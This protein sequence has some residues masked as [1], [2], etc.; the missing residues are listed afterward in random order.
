[1]MR[2]F[3]SV[4]VC[5]SCTSVF[6]GIVQH[7]PQHIAG[8]RG[9]WNATWHPSIELWPQAGAGASF[10]EFDPAAIESEVDNVLTTHGGWDARVIVSQVEWV[11]DPVPADLDP[12]A[13]SVDIDPGTLSWFSAYAYNAGAGSW[14]YGS[15]NYGSFAAA[16]LA[17][18]ATGDSAVFEPNPSQWQAIWKSSAENPHAGRDYWNVVIDVPESLIMHYLRNPSADGLFVGSRK[19][20][21]DIDVFGYDQWG[22]SVD[23]RVEIAPPPQTAPWITP[24]PA[25]L[26]LMMH[27]GD[28]IS[29]PYSVAVNNAGSGMLS[30]TAAEAPEVPWITL[31]NPSGSNG[32]TFDVTIDVTDMTPGEY[33]GRIDITDAAAANAPASVWIDLTVFASGSPQIELAPSELNMDLAPSAAPPAAMPVVVDNPAFGVLNWT[34]S[35]V[36][37][38]VGWLSLSNTTGSDGDTLLVH[39]DHTGVARGTHTAQI[40]VSDPAAE[41]SPQFIPV[42]LVVRDQDADLDLACGYDD[43]WEDGATGWVAH[44]RELYGSKDPAVQTHGFVVRLGDSITYANPGGQWA[45]YGSGKTA[46]DAAICNWMHSGDTWPDPIHNNSP[47]GWY[48]SR[49]DVPGRNG[50]YTA[51]SSI[52]TEGMLSGWGGLPSADQMFTA[53]D[54]NPDGKQYRDAEIVVILLGTNDV[55]GPRP[56]ASFIADL[57]AIV[58]RVEVNN[59]VVA[60]TT[61]PPR[62]NRESAVADYNAA[63]RSLA[64]SRHLPLIDLYEEIVRR[65]PD[66]SWDGTLISSDGVHPSASHGGYSA[67]SSPYTDNGAAL[68]HSGYLLWCWLTVQKVNEIKGKCFDEEPPAE[69]LDP[70]DPEVDVV[71]NTEDTGLAFYAGPRNQAEW[72]INRG[73]SSTVRIKNHDDPA[74]LKWDLSVYAGQTVTHAELHVARSNPSSEVFALAAATINTDWDEGTTGNGVDGNPCWRYR[75]YNAASPEESVEWTFPGSDFTT[76]S[77]GNFGSLTTLSSK[78][79]GT[80]KTYDDGGQTWI[81]MKLDPALVH[82]MV[83]DQYGLT[84]TDGRGRTWVNPSIY[85]SEQSSALQPRLYLKTTQDDVTGPGDVAG[86]TASPGEWDGEVVLSFAAPEDTEDGRAFGYDVRYSIGSDFAAA[87]PV[88]RWRIPRPLDAGTVQTVFIEHLDPQ[89]EYHFFVQAYDKAGNRGN[90]VSTVLTL[91]AASDVPSLIDGGFPVPDPTGKPILGVSGVLSLWACS[92]LAKVNPATGNR[93][94]DGYAGAGND[95]YKKANAVWDS[96]TATVDLPAGRNEVVAFQLIIERL[97]ESLSNVSVAGS[98]LVGPGGATIPT[99]EYLELFKL[100]YVSDDG[101]YYPDPAIPLSAPFAGTFD[102]PSVNNPGGVC[103]SVWADLYVPRT[104]DAGTYTG[105]ISIDC[106]QLDDPLNISLTVRV[107]PVTIPDKSTFLLDLNGYGNKWSSESS[108]YQVF[109]L[110][111]KHRA[112]PNTLPYGWTG[113]VNEDRA[114]VLSG[115]GA[116]TTI[117]DWSLFT[118]HYGPFLDGTGFSPTHPTYPYHGPGENTPVAD[119]YTAF[120][121]G[122]PVSLTDSV[123]GFDASGSGWAYWNGLVDSDDTTAWHD[124]PDAFDAFDAEYETG[125]RQVAREFAEYAQDRGW[126]DTAFQMYLNNKY[127][128]DP[129]ISLWTLEE[130]AVADD[131]RATA[132]FLNLAKQGAE[133]ADAPDVD[134]QWRIDTSTRWGQNWGQLRGTCDLRVMGGDIEW[135]YRQARYRR[136][137]EP[138]DESW[139]W[140]GTGPAAT[141]PLTG[142]SAD[143]LRHWS[144]GLDGALP[145]WDNY[146]TDWANADALAVLPSGDNVPGHGS[147]DGRIAT[148]RLKGMRHG[149]QLAEHLNVLSGC[150]GWNRTRVARAL[151]ERYGDHTGY[152]FDPFGG[153]AYD[154]MS[155][156]DFHRLHADLLASIAAAQSM[157]DLDGQ[158]GADLADFAVLW[159]ALEGPGIASDSPAD[160]DADGDVDLR[161]YAEFQLCTLGEIT[162]DTAE[163]T[164]DWGARP[165][166][167]PVTCED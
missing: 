97:A 69:W 93:M 4:L 11:D 29:P 150:E 118:D 128:Y 47:N 110:C 112:V 139:W 55:S 37:A 116:S 40:Q 68:S 76:A 74:L 163:A 75:A 157:C 85:T 87:I 127:Y 26:T 60:L 73:T 133:S 72:L 50:S 20:D 92:D 94:S 10:A 49:V 64:Q 161:D 107:H 122:W 143:T 12:V 101:V 114:P 71:L 58:D 27:G 34:A 30:W 152:A 153:D 102:V 148:I 15:T 125:Y 35:V 158:G 119:F 151:S 66:D 5:L 19:T 70:D 166:C 88:D 126:H 164:G 48:L 52:T 17:G 130:H 138:I 156:L 165:T 24:T 142:H 103:Q 136:F 154:S 1:M 144:H 108:R 59:T 9:G 7:T 106:D 104:A 56:T 14:R 141:D 167:W 109:Q 120:H 43:A 3:W 6:G 18:V 28:P 124:M 145:Y 113:G 149:V 46:S 38:P 95:D 162:V 8:W 117:D 61:L 135:Y 89:Q 100:H 123:W 140:Y 121:E 105:T 13:G 91:P 23:I 2:T 78:H 42:T 44:G 82:A 131:F 63:V 53:G 16:V 81:A 99:A 62:R 31:A 39:V 84:I 65:R 33:S 32:D 90:V 132:Y 77:F 21:G 115:T 41:N 134:W 80:F 22:G 137:A 155:I 57:E 36:D 79:G 25:T 83:L 54:T 98:D 159:N 86:L 67:A 129:C 45:Q 51:R 146:H 96:A 111:H 160:M 147:F